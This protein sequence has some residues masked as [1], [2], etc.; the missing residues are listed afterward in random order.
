MDQEDVVYVYK[1][2]YHSAM[3]KNEILPFRTTWVDLEG[4]MLSEK[5]QRKV[6]TIWFHSYVEFK[7]QYKWAKGE[8]RETNQEIDSTIEN[9]LMVTRGEVGGMG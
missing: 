6:D 5:H 1:I 3:Q 7:K 9:K 4:I 2:E 8:K